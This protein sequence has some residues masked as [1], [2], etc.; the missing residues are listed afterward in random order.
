MPG[1]K[2][3]AFANL[4]VRNGG[5]DTYES[6]SARARAREF[7][8]SVLGFKRG[9]VLSLLGEAPVASCVYR[10]RFHTAAAGALKRIKIPPAERR[11]VWEMR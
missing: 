2:S 3:S 1:G 7:P 11:A 10:R 5:I 6:D 9:P 8:H 4:L